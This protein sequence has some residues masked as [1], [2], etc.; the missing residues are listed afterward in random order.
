MILAAGR[1]ERL[2]PL[3]DSLP[4][5]LIEVGGETLI[6]RHLHRL[7]AAGVDEVV[8]NLGWLGERIEAALG[9]G[10][11][12]GLRIAYSREGWP[13]LETGGG[14]Y[15]ALS[16]L[17]P[18]PFALISADIWTDYPIA[19]LIQ[20]ARALPPRDLAH[21]V[22][23]DNPPFN[24]GGDFALDGDRVR[25]QPRDLTFANLSVLHPQLFRDCHSGVFP[26]APLWRRAA[27]AGRVGGERFHGRW[28][29]VGSREL[30]QALT[31]AIGNL[32]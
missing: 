20:R 25:N 17:G 32:A 18:H 4:K 5:P 11:R 23:V 9:D 6:E 28:W 27:E 31:A 26:L 15:R 21:L 3:T 12:Y 8:I 7:A 19:A 16:L 2:R 24:A 10:A 13:A 1:G 22:L 30:L 14:V 29:N